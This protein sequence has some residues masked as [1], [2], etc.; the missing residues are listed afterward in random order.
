MAM[1]KTFTQSLGG[2]EGGGGLKGGFRATFGGFYD[3]FLGG[4]I[5][6]LEW[7][8][9]VFTVFCGRRSVG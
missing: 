3:G 7:F 4:F 9:S 6:V 1:K 5:A 2:L 8:Y